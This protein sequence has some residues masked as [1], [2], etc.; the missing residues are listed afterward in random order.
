MLP[1]DSNYYLREALGLKIGS[2]GL[3]GDGAGDAVI[4]LQEFVDFDQVSAVTQ[5]LAAVAYSRKTPGVWFVDPRGWVGQNLFKE[6]S[7]WDIPLVKPRFTCTMVADK[8]ESTSRK[9]A[10]V[11]Q[12]S[13]DSF[14]NGGKCANGLIAGAP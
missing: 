1:G 12:S 7:I 14:A 5:V 11:L 4:A 10:Q 3:Q 2:E 13:V 8:L 6:A 9:T